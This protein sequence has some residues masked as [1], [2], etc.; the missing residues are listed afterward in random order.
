MKSILIASL[1]VLTIS[2]SLSVVSLARQEKT[3][4][5]VAET[6]KVKPHRKEYT[7][8]EL[9]KLHQEAKLKVQQRGRNFY[10]HPVEDNPGF[11]SLLISD[12]DGRI[13]T[14]EYRLAQISIFEAI[15]VEAE[16][17]AVSPQDVG[18]SKPVITRFFDKKEPSFF[19][20]VAK[21]GNESQFFITVKS[22]TDQITVDTG[23]I[24]RSTPKVKVFFHEV[25]AQ[26]QAA[27][28]KEDDK[29]Q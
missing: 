1:S 2:L 25:L 24:K 16:K 20:D 26:I 23:R 22:L 3:K 14:G 9:N 28:P 17:F 8:A 6:Q 21:Q 29:K 13:I 18:T 10:I 12:Q 7:E 27:K 4:P 19:V 15:M 11:Y 5:P